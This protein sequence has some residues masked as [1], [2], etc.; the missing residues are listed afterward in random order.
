MAIELPALLDVKA[1]AIVPGVSEPEKRY[2]QQASRLLKDGYCDHS[3]L[4]VWNAAVSNLRRRVEMYGLDLF[5]SV[6]KDEPGR[7][8][9]APEGETPADRWSG[10]DE[11]VLIGA[12][13]SCW[14]NRKKIKPRRGG[15]TDWITVA[16]SGLRI[17]LRLPGVG[18]PGYR[19]KPL[20]GG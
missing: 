17:L 5:Q 13:A 11:L 18:T 10:V 2:L 1:L 15:D 3:L 8:R 16:P 12:K 19:P 4:D 20:R 6:V 14:C 9:Y 7:K